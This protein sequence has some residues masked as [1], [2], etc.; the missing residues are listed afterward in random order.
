MAL[1][2]WKP[3]AV[4]LQAQGKPLLASAKSTIQVL[5]V[6]IIPRHCFIA[7][8]ILGSKNTKDFWRCVISSLNFCC[9]ST[10]NM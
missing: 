9:I 10:K 7:S 4:S 2:L 6:S 5:S 3:I 1:T 8:Y